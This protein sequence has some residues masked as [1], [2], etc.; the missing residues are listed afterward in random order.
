MKGKMALT[1]VADEAKSKH[2]AKKPCLLGWALRCN[3]LQINTRSLQ[4]AD[5]DKNIF[6]TCCYAAALMPASQETAKVCLNLRWW[7]QILRLIEKII[8]VKVI[9]HRNFGDF[10]PDIV[11]ISV[12]QLLLE[13]SFAHWKQQLIFFDTLCV[14]DNL[15]CV[16]AI[17]LC[18]LMKTVN[19]E[20]ICSL[21]RL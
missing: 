17:Y 18:Y 19:G 10:L 9:S 6:I 4:E 2:S 16:A 13:E 12:V 11:H 21:F 7:V 5:Q 15:H 14:A 8:T 20:T 3:L 1:L